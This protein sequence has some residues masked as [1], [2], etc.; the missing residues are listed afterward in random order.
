MFEAI[1]QG[2]TAGLTSCVDIGGIS[3]QTE[4]VFKN[5]KAVLKAAGCELQHVVKTTGTI[6]SNI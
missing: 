2:T 1:F 4:Q 3:E 6:T 5:L